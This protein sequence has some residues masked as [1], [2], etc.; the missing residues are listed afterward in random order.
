[1]DAEDS[2]RVTP[3]GCTNGQVTKLIGGVAEPKPD[4]GVANHCF[5]TL[6]ENPISVHM[7]EMSK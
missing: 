6:Y 1:M 5:R 7:R 4:Y 2:G 3:I